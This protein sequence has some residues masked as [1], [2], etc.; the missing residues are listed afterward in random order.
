VALS[1]R[2]GE[3]GF[4]FILNVAKAEA[5]PRA[6]SGISST[7]EDF[8]ARYGQ[9]FADGTSGESTEV[10]EKAPADLMWPVVAREGDR[11]IATPQ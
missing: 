3:T 2:A 4:C 1:R 10:T 11:R 9:A 8:A 6:A 5:K 7:T